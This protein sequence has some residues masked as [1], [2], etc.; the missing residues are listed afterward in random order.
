MLNV[1]K[2]ALSCPSP[3]CTNSARG[4]C[5]RIDPGVQKWLFIPEWDFSGTGGTQHADRVATQ[6][7]HMPSLHPV[8]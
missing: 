1:S 3:R 2:Q 5:C 6:Q 8:F 7:D 4:I